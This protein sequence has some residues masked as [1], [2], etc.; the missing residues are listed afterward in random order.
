MQQENITNNTILL[1]YELKDTFNFGVY[2]ILRGRYT[3]ICCLRL[4]CE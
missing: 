2:I 3:D 1:K 4:T